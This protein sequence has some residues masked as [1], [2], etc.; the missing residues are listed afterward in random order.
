MRAFPAHRR[1]ADSG[2]AALTFDDGPDPE[3]TPR[4]LDVLAAHGVPATFFLVGRRVRRHPQLVRRML[5]DGHAVGSH[6]YAHTHGPEVSW[7]VLARDVWHGRRALEEVAGRSVEAFRPPMGYYAGRMAL[8]ARVSGLRSW[9]WTVDPT[10]WEPGR[11]ARAILD[12]VGPLAGGDVVRL[13]DGIE[14]PLAPEAEDRSA[15]VSAL[16]EIIS[17]AREEGLRLVPLEERR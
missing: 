16:P 5:A 2:G 8:A 11:T 3:F 14:S 12:A 15:T 4:V 13:H 7:P 10:D 9:L 1:L 6:T 17:R